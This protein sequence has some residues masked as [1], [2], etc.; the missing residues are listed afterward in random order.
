MA[1]G[2]HMLKRFSPSGVPGSSAWTCGALPAKARRKRS[3]TY[4]L[5]GPH[6]P[7]EGAEGALCEFSSAVSR[8]LGQPRA[9]SPCKSGRMLTTNPPREDADHSAPIMITRASGRIAPH[10]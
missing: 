5:G 10:S 7:L 1:N 2:L 3:K 9:A 6:G 4:S 8:R